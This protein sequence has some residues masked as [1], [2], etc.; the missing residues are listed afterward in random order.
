LDNCHWERVLLLVVTLSLL[1][2]CCLDNC[3]R[4]RVLLLVV[5]LSLLW[6]CCLDNCLRERVLLVVTLSLLWNC[7]LDNCHRERVLL[8]VVALLWN[9]CL[10]NCLREGVLLVVTLSLKL[11]FGQLSFRCS[12]W[13]WHGLLLSILLLANWLY[14]KPLWH[15][16]CLREAAPIGDIVRLWNPCS[17][18]WLHFVQYLE[19]SSSKG[20][21]VYVKTFLLEIILYLMSISTDRIFWGQKVKCKKMGFVLSMLIQSVLVLDNTDLCNTSVVPRKILT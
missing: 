1:W 20:N 4:G 6:N 8:L 14:D 17:G 3:L 18:N 21:F 16:L 11:H 5:T 2:N 7:C 15:H 13:L 10:D 19:H 9:C 12:S